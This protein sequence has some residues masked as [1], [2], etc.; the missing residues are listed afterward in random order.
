MD[1]LFYRNWKKNTIKLEREFCHKNFL[2]DCKHF[3]LIPKFMQL[4]NSFIEKE[5][6]REL[7]LFQQKILASYIR[8]KYR[9]INGFKKRIATLEEENLPNYSSDEI[10]NMQK[11]I[12]T[13]KTREN[14][15]IS[16]KHRRKLKGWL[17][18]SKGK[19]N[20][21]PPLPLILILTFP[22]LFLTRIKI[23]F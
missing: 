5:F 23:Y 8:R 17:S 3:K 21:P 19:Q 11:R 4:R 13:I 2:V 14:E 6:P 16:E 12:S 9:N 20:P 15:R 1:N 7:Q 18:Y 22:L 10:A